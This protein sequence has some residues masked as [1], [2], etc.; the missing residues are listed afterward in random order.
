MSNPPKIFR[1]FPAGLRDPYY[2]NKKLLKI[3]WGAGEQGAGEKGA[4]E[5]GAGEKRERK[6]LAK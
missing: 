6:N 1:H 5:K 2:F 4:G 3:L